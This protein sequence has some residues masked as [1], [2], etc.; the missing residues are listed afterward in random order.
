MAIR[1]GQA[2]LLGTEQDELTRCRAT[3]E[4]Q[5]V[6]R[7][8]A[9]SLEDSPRSFCGGLQQKYVAV[10]VLSER[11]EKEPSSSEANRPGTWIR[12]GAYP[13]THVSY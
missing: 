12:P 4:Q 2:R 10:G 1:M 9:W 7:G 8:E 13:S 11:A 6:V 3:E 5:G